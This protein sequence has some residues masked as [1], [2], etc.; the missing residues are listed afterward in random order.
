[1]FITSSTISSIKGPRVGLHISLKVTLMIF[2]YGTGDRGPRGLED[3]S[4]L[5][6]ISGELL[7]SDGVKDS[8]LYT[9]E[10]D[11]SRTRLCLD[12]TGEGGDDDGTCLRLPRRG[13]LSGI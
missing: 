8:R 1:V 5:D 9:K 11:G 6:M 12:S 7:T 3:E 4:A 10:R 2:P 13:R